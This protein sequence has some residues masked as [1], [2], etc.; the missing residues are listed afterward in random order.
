[1]MAESCPVTPPVVDAL[2]RAITNVLESYNGEETLSTLLEVGVSSE[3]NE[4]SVKVFCHELI[5]TIRTCTSELRRTLRAP[6]AREKVLRSFH[7]LRISRLLG[8]WKEVERKL[9][10]P[11]TKAVL[12]QSVNR[13]LFIEVLLKHFATSQSFSSY[14]TKIINVFK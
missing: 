14:Y 13:H 6:E 1:M 12:M 4:H 2:R 7:Q 11:G 3:S 10:L 9:G 8:V 5:G